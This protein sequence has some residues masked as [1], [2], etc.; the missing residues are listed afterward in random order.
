M[1]IDL[2]I[3]FQHDWEQ[4]LKE[5]ILI[6]KNLSHLPY[7]QFNSPKPG[8]IKNMLEA[9]NIIQFFPEATEEHLKLCSDRWK[10]FN[11]L[12]DENKNISM[13]LELLLA[14]GQ[15]DTNQ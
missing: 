14:K 8:E 15:T 3:F 4:L 5:I 13:D 2:Q 10:V 7:H 6:L 9:N 12:F 11:D 1:G